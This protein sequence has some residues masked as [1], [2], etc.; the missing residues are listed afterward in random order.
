MREICSENSFSLSGVFS[1]E[2]MPF[3]PLVLHVY[4]VHSGQ[5][6]FRIK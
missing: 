3:F 6:G 1:V 2:K 4:I 5:D